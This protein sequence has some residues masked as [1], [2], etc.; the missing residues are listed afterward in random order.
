[1]PFGSRMSKRVDVQLR[2]PC[3]LSEVFLKKQI[4]SKVV[5]PVQG[6]IL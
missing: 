4:K 1:M 5:L 3:T 2:T 6:E